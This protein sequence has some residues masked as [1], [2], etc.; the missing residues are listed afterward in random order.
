MKRGK[1]GQG[2]KTASIDDDAIALDDVDQQPNKAE[3]GI[4]LPTVRSL[5]LRILL[6]QYVAGACFF[7]AVAQSPHAISSDAPLDSASLTAHS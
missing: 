7:Y 4:V 1:K 3:G 2:T 6:D 5:K